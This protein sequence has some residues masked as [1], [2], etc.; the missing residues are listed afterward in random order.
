MYRKRNRQSGII[1][2]VRMTEQE[3][4]AIKWM[5]N[6]RDDAIV[7]LDHIFKKE[8]NVSPMLYAGRKE[9]AETIIKAFEELQQYWA[10]GLTPKMVKSMI[11]SEQEACHYSLIHDA[12][13]K[14]Y[15][16]I[17]T[18]EECRE[19]VEKQRAKK[20]LGGVDVDG[21]EYA[22]CRECSAILSDGEWFA[23]YCPDCGQA[24]DWSEEK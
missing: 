15:K 18:V 1:G 16:E 11:K 12:V 9:K 8:P 19:A 17:G 3:Q 7:T 24:I 20:P 21:N 5:Q 13:L 2:G 10:I 14:Q 22:I 4:K 23:K 6:V